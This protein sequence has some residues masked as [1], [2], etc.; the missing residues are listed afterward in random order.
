MPLI[1]QYCLELESVSIHRSSTSTPNQLPLSY[2]VL[3]KP[4]FYTNKFVI[5]FANC[6]PNLEVFSL[7]LCERVHTVSDSCVL[8]LS[9]HCPELCEVEL[10]CLSEDTVLA[11]PVTASKTITTLTLTFNSSSIL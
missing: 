6:C 8:A 10:Q 2:I 7:G 9:E 1:S 4:S 5:S 3:C 11:L